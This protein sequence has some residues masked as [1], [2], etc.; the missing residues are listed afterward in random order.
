MRGICFKIGIILVVLVL[1][2]QLAAAVELNIAVSPQTVTQGEQIIVTVTQ[3]G[4]TPVENVFLQFTIDEGTPIYAVTNASGQAV[5]TPEIAGTLKIVAMKDDELSVSKYITVS[6]SSDG[7]GGD[8]GDGGDGNG[9]I[10]YWWSGSVT[11]PSGTFTKTTFDTNKT[12]PIKWWSALGALQK[13]SEGNFEYKIEETTWGPF[14]YSI[15]DKEKY[16]EGGTSGWMYQVNGESP[17]IGAHEYAVNIGDE[18]I[19]YFSKSMDTTPSTSSR[20]LRI[21]IVSSGGDYSG[22]GD[23]ISPTPTPAPT[24]VV[25]EVKEIEPIEAGE[26]ASVTF[27]KTD[28]T[29]IIINARNTIRNAEVA[30]QQ[31]EKRPENITNISGIPYRYFNVTTTNLTDSDIA[32]ATIKFKVNK[33]WIN[34]SNIDEV[35]ITLS[36][37]CDINWNALPTTKIKEDN[38]SLYFEAETPGFS[39]FAISG[40]VKTVPPSVSVP[41]TTIL[42]ST[43]ATTKDTSTPAIALTLASTLPALVSIKGIIIT[44]VSIAL[45]LIVLVAY[46]TLRIRRGKE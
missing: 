39:L 29:R 22:S 2:T 6:Q 9:G 32:N 19:W 40:E 25:E 4:G 7:N 27:E 28:I 15:A 26:T 10:S 5:F 12:Y 30:I 45:L 34:A 3:D 42:P 11:L 46:F 36:R 44:T 21:K 37:Y 24:R 16:D 8:G 13:A 1:L 17:M 31:I 41:H 38:A 43:A 20:A 14:V 33:T 35:T 18:V 23:G